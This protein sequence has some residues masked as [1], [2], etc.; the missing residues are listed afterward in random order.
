MSGPQQTTLTLYL[1]PLNDTFAPKRIALSPQQRVKIGRQT[2]SQTVPTDGNGYFDSKILS[3][4]HSEV[5]EQ[6]GKV[7][8]TS[9]SL[10]G[11]RG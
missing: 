10:S 9:P 2:N 1:W 11:T 5:W 7:I 6:D 4:Q 8:A 3:R